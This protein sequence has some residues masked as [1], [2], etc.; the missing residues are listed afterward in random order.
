MY[1]VDSELRTRD[2]DS[3]QPRGFSFRLLRKAPKRSSMMIPTAFNGPPSVL[4]GNSD[5][6]LVPSPLSL[7]LSLSTFGGW[8]HFVMFPL[9]VLASSFL[10]TTLLK[11][12][13]QWKTG[14][15]N[16]WSWRNFFPHLSLSTSWE[17]SPLDIPILPMARTWSKFFFLLEMSANLAVSVSQTHKNCSSQFRI[18]VIEGYMAVS[19]FWIRV[20][21]NHSLT[22]I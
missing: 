10:C 14:R 19:S 9:C 6:I 2:E 1:Q 3:L 7:S 20:S 11:D 8:E 13:K 21:V 18:C 4:S 22:S 15:R 17:V 5:R 12:R 16:S